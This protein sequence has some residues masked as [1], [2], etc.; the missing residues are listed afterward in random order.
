[1]LNRKNNKPHRRNPC[2]FLFILLNAFLRDSYFSIPSY[3]IKNLKLTLAVKS[4]F[5]SFWTCNGCFVKL[6]PIDA[7]TTSCDSYWGMIA[8]NFWCKC[9]NLFCIFSLFEPVRSK[10]ELEHSK[11]IPA[12]I[13]DLLNL[14]K[15]YFDTVVSKFWLT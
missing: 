8:L 1:M 7:A 2:R 6:N 4:C 15:W 3:N 14:R 9:H 5:W 13:L 11:V 12:E 10:V